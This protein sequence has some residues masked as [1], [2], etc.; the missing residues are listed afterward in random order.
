[1]RGNNNKADQKAHALFKHSEKGTC[2]VWT[3]GGLPDLFSSV[4]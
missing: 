1:M 2:V 4:I 3:Q